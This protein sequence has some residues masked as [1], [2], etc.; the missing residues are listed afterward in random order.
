MTL[1]LVSVPVSSF[2]NKELADLTV[3]PMWNMFCEGSHSMEH[4]SNFFIGGV[5]LLDLVM[6]YLIE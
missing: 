5:L 3:F 2:P 6:N 4:V 1:N